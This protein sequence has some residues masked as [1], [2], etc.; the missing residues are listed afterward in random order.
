VPCHAL[1]KLASITE[2]V[3]SFAAAWGE[4]LTKAMLGVS[5]APFPVDFTVETVLRY[6]SKKASETK[7][8]G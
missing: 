8:R 7:I 2:R 1:E 3:P 5:D 6:I 4:R